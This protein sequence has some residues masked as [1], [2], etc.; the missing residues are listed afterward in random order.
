VHKVLREQQQ[1]LAVIKDRAVYK[2]LRE[3]KAIGVHEVNRVDKVRQVYEA[4]PV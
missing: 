4:L 2:A 3:H 1:P